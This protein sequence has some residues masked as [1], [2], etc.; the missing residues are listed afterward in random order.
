MKENHVNKRV[1]YHTRKRKGVLKSHSTNAIIIAR[2]E[3]LT[4]AMA[5]L[6]RQALAQ[7][8]IHSVK[9]SQPACELGPGDTLHS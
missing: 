2:L 1:D 3:F 8:T 5:L 7:E 4:D 9:F 6:S